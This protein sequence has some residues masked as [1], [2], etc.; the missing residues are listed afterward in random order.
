MRACEHVQQRLGGRWATEVEDLVHNT[1]VMGVLTPDPPTSQEGRDQWLLSASDPSYV[2][3]KSKGLAQSGEFYPVAPTPTLPR[4]QSCSGPL[5]LTLT[6]A[7]QEGTYLNSVSHSGTCSFQE[8]TSSLAEAWRKNKSKP[9]K[10]YKGTPNRGKGT[11]L[12]LKAK[13]L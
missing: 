13:I 10:G 1:S 12:V 3:F 2:Q 4:T 6:E 11:C 9:D 5:A 8:G 7:L